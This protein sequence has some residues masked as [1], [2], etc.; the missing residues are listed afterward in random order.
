MQRS[1]RQVSFALIAGTGL[2]LGGCATKDDVQAAQK[3]ADAA[4]VQADAAMSA[5][6][7]AQSASQAAAQKADQAA[8]EA[9]SANDKIDQLTEEERNESKAERKRHPRPEGGERG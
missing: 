3:A 1:I 9:K 4:R 7:A 8:A 2:L 6:Q 5:A